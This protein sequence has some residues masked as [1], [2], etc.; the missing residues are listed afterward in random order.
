MLERHLCTL[1]WLPIWDPNYSRVRSLSWAATDHSFHY[2]ILWMLPWV[3]N[4]LISPVSIVG[5]NEERGIHASSLGTRAPTGKLRAVLFQLLLTWVSKICTKPFS[6]A[7]TACQLTP[8]LVFAFAFRILHTQFS[9][10]IVGWLWP[11]QAQRIKSR[12]RRETEWT[13]MLYLGSVIA[14]SVSN[15]RH[16]LPTLTR[17]H[18]SLHCLLQSTYTWSQLPSTFQAIYWGQF[19]Q[20]HQFLRSRTM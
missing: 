7:F 12:M 5:V 3:F 19:C 1:T 18:L 17:I 14:A 11:R 8:R 9:K 10:L 2:I 15:L 6:V 16:G 20:L 4:D 13:R